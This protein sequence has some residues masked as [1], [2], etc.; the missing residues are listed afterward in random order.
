MRNLIRGVYLLFVKFF[1][2]I[3]CMVYF[4]DGRIALYN[5]LTIGLR[6]L[7]KCRTTLP[8]PFGIVI[9]K[10][11]V[12]GYDCRVYQ[13]VTIGSKFKDG[14]SY[15]IIGNNVTI[16]ANS[17][18]VGNVK[19]GDNVIIGASTLVIKDIPANSVVIGNPARII[20]K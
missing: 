20:E 12:L 17:V 10:G 3:Y 13:G 5:E 2:I 4:N 15:P 16:Y 18:I 19:I 1:K 14:L 9:G 8:H 7:C 6:T 11:V